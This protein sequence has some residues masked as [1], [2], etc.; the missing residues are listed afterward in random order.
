[1]IYHGDALDFLAAIPDGSVNLIVTDPP[2][3][4]RNTKAGKSRLQDGLNSSQKDLT[5]HNLD[6]CQGIKWC[7]QIKRIQGGK[8]NCYIWCNKA[9]IPQYFDYFIDQ[10]KCSFDI[11]IWY[12]PNAPPT[13]Y[14]KWMSDKEYCLYFRKSGWCMPEKYQDAST[15][16]THPMNQRDKKLYGHPTVKPLPIIE[17]LIRNSSKPGDLVVDPYVGSGT[18][19][20]AA[21]KLDRRFKGAEL[22]QQFAAVAQARIC[23]AVIDK[24]VNKS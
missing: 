13:F 8:I 16:F 2:Y 10:L 15:V 9:Q 12:K 1:M 7:K 14:N 4:I 24:T 11:I 18:T 5:D 17:R 22:D 20:H 23:Q 6:K 19:G 21:I 3:D